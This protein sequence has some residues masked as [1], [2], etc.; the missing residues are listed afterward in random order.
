M[1][2]R[3]CGG[4]TVHLVDTFSIHEGGS[5][6]L[7]HVPSDVAVRCFVQR[8]LA[9]SHRFEFDVAD[10]SGEPAA[11]YF[12]MTDELSDIDASDLSDSDVWHIG[13]LFGVGR[14][15][16]TWWNLS[17]ASHDDDCRCHPVTLLEILQDHAT[18]G[19]RQASLEAHLRALHN[20][21]DHFWS[22]DAVINSGSDTLNGAC[23][24]CLVGGRSHL[25]DVLDEARNLAEELG[26]ALAAFHSRID[27]GIDRY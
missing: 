26:E 19:T 17:D 22:G 13:S 10:G 1:R 5:Y 3:P 4:G 2:A 16:P 14:H 24:E 11:A 20:V 6:I 25:E 21:W 7:F 18:G 12:D 8:S 15:S 9:D 27:I 23:A